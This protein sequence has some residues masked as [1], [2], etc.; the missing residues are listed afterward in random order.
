MT[1]DPAARAVLDQLARVPPLHT[2]SVEDARSFLVAF[3]RALGPGEPVARVEDR[4]VPVT[5]AGLPFR[6]YTPSGTGPFPVLVYFHGGGWTVGNLDTEDAACRVM[7]NAAKCIVASVNYRHAPEH[8]FP[9]APNDAYEATLWLAK[10]A[11]NFGGDPSR[12]A[13]GG[14]SAGAN[15]AAVVSLMARERKQPDI[16]FQALITPV[17][18]YAFEGAS[19]RECAVGYGLE[20]ATMEWFWNHYLSTPGD[21]EHVYVSPLRALDLSGL[22]PALIVTAQYDPIRDEG[23]AYA[24]RLQS[25]GV[26][27][28]Y[29]CCEGM[30]HL[31]L[32]PSALPTVASQL[33]AVFGMTSGAAASPPLFR[34]PGRR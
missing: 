9:A 17:T 4:V 31:Y 29:I 18:D 2:L 27:V 34:L 24:E 30:I 11:G 28:T 1:L 3:S 6:L 19:H 20:R 8:K 13:V 33:R 16:C 21:G 22:P 14:T 23:H 15:L 26:P 25:A 10:N 32:G 12:L 5:A 7:C